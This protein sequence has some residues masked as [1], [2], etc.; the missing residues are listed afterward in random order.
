MLYKASKHSRENVTSLLLNLVSDP[1]AIG[2]ALYIATI[3]NYINIVSILLDKFPSLNTRLT[4]YKVSELGYT[5]VVYILLNK[6]AS[7][8]HYNYQIAV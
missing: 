8:K 5:S 7:L 1:T 2:R 4:L 3:R 6:T